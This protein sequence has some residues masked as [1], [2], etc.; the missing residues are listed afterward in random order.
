MSF[1]ELFPEPFLFGQCPTFISIV[2][3]MLIIVIAGGAIGAVGPRGERA[4]KPI[5]D[6]MRR[7]KLEEEYAVERLE[8]VVEMKEEYAVERM[9]EYVGESIAL[10]SW[11]NGIKDDGDSASDGIEVVVTY[12][13]A[14]VVLVIVVVF[15][16]SFTERKTIPTLENTIL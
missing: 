11:H 8:Y 5:L 1:P 15:Q 4:G 7:Q 3:E 9:E 6:S 10:A 16:L 13:V 14:A 2:V 12:L